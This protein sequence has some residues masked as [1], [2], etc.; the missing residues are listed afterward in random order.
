MSIQW[1]GEQNVCIKTNYSVLKNVKRKTFNLGVVLRRG[2]VEIFW[3]LKGAV[4]N[5]SLTVDKISL[6]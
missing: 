1:K 4:G 3:S 2:S 5:L 6:F